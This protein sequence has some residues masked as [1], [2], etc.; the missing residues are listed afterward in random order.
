MYKYIYIYI[1][2]EKKKNP[3]VKLRELLVYISPNGKAQWKKHN[4]LLM[5]Q[6]KTFPYSQNVLKILFRGYS[7][8]LHIIYPSGLIT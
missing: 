7:T 4:L 6:Q 2:N 1:S 5:C 3:L 8:L